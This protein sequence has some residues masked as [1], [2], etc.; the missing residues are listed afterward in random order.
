[1]VI[2]GGFNRPAHRGPPIRQAAKPP[3]RQ[4][5][6]PPNRRSAKLPIR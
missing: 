3:I 2:F 5:A 4:T 1:M 6:D